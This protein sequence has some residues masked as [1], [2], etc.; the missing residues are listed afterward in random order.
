MNSVVHFEIPT[1]DLDKAKAFYQTVFGWKMEQFDGDN[2][3]ATTTESDAKGQPTK[4]GAING[5]LYKATGKTANFVIDVPDLN[6]HIQMVKANGGTIIDEP[7]AIPGMGMYARFHD[8]DGNLIGLWQTLSESTDVA[9]AKPAAEA[10]EPTFSAQ[11]ATLASAPMGE[12]ETTPPPA[13][14]APVTPTPVVTP[15]PTPATTTPPAAPSPVVTPS[16]T[17]PAIP[18]APA[19]MP[20]TPAPTLSPAPTGATAE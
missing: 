17:P 20:A 9:T 10:P 15:P 5:S 4:P 8:P 16:V 11:P 19:V 3:M 7:K 13:A 18:A 1:Q 2:V 12:T 6:V 14:P